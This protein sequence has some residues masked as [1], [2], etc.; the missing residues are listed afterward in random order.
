MQ[1]ACGHRFCKACVDELLEQQT[2]SCPMDNC[3]EPITQS[4][5]CVFVSV[6]VIV[7]Y[8]T[9]LNSYIVTED[10]KRRYSIL[11]SSVVVNGSERL[12]KLM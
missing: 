6:C 8:I 10:V 1:T 9:Y 12:K 2:P 11:M 7:L 4:E 5:V 3:K